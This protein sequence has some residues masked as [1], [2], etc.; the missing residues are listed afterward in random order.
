MAVNST[1]LV[2]I[3]GRPNV[4]KSSLF[5]RLVGT[6][7]AI[8]HDSAGTTRD[9][10]YGAAQ[11]ER[12]PLHA[13]RHRRPVQSRRRYRAAGARP[14]QANGRSRRRSRRSRGRRHHDHHRR[15]GRR[16][17]GARSGKPVILALNKID[18]ATGADLDAWRRLGIQTMW[19]FRPFTAAAP[20]TCSMPLRPYPKAT[21]RRPGA[22][23][24]RPHR[25]AQRRQIQ[26]GQQP[27]RQTSHG[28]FSHARHH[29]RHVLRA[30]QVPGPRDRAHRHRRPAPP[31]PHRSRASRNSAPCAPSLPSTKPISAC[32]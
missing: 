29:P 25:P 1:P 12:P 9:A 6:R 19:A 23:Q 11:L 4:G 32:S 5:N 14:D 2:A 10:N 30:N 7:Q 31:R 21:R 20:A 28:G 13:G 16:P 3:V 17:P 22:A 27:A 24:A 18:T 26:P 15:P 8:T